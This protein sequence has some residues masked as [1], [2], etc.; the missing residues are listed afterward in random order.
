MYNQRAMF[1]GDQQPT[2]LLDTGHCFSGDS[3][4]DES[5]FERYSKSSVNL[6]LPMLP[7]FLELPN[8]FFKFWSLEYCGQFRETSKNCVMRII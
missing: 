8:I 2:E 3:C 6:P 1:H 7:S 5:S 4:S